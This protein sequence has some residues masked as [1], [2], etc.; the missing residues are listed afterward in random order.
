MPSRL[1]AFEP[2]HFKVFVYIP[3]KGKTSMAGELDVLLLP[4]KSGMF[5]CI[6]EP[7]GES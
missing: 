4:E 3:E 7:L 6:R 1:V 5:P 2:T